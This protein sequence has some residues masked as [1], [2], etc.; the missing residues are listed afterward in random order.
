LAETLRRK[1]DA[2]IIVSYNGFDIRDS[3]SILESTELC[4][5]HLQI[6]YTGTIYKKWQDPSMLFL[7]LQML[8]S[9]AERISV[10][11]YGQ[12]LDH[13]NDLSKQFGVQ[14]F[15]EV[16]EP[17]PYK[18]CLRLQRQA[19]VL[20]LLQ[21]SDPRQKGIYTGKLF[22]YIGACRPILSIGPTDNEP[23]ELIAKGG[24]GVA[25]NQPDD[26]AVQLRQWIIQK[27][28]Q[29]IPPVPIE[30]TLPYSRDFQIKHV[31]RFLQAILS[32]D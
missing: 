14:S 28:Q 16:H 31:E 24:F 12:G 25:L 13:M 23:A 7:A 20:L 17:V 32:K 26:I 4:V 27:E 15:V 2:P 10:S 3:T 30:A 22:E 18:E 29:G 5:K 19:D 21:W 1:Y 6:V 11:F 8:G 9:Q